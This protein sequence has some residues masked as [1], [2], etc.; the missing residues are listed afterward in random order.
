MMVRDWFCPLTPKKSKNARDD[1]IPAWA[2]NDS[3][4]QLWKIS[5][6]YAASILKL[7]SAICFPEEIV[8][9]RYVTIQVF[10]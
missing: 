8:L 5:H 1:E 6:E 10:K 9:P 2:I 4:L 7:T 3:C